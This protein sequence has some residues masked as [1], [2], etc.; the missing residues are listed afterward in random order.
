MFKEG[1]LFAFTLEPFTPENSSI[2]KKFTHVFSQTYRRFLDLQKAEAQ[3][4]EAQIE[5]SLERVRARAMAMQ[6]SSELAELVATLFKELTRL[7]FALTRCYIYIIDPDTLSLQ[8][9]TS[10]TEVDE[11]PTI[12]YLDLP[13]YKALIKAWK[14]RKQKFVYE[15]GGEEKKKV[16]RVLLNET[17][18]SRLPEAVKSGMMSVDRVFLSY[19]FNNFGGLQTG[20]L[21]PLS[22][23][24]L[25]IFSRFGKVFDLTYTRFNDL[26]QAEAQAKEAQIQLALE[27]VRARTMAMQSSEELAEVSYLLNKQVVELGIPTRGCAFNIYNE[28]DST[29]WFS[30]LDGTIPTY[31]TPRENIFLKYYEAGQ[32]GEMLLI[33]EFGGERIKEHY[34]YLATLSVAGSFIEKIEENVQVVP[35]FQIDHVAYFKYGYLLF[36]TLVPAPEAHD[37]FKRFAKEFEQTYTRFLDLKK[38]EAQAREAQIEAALERVRSRTMGMRH[39]DELQEAAVLLF[40]Q[41]VALGVP[42]FATGFNIWD[43]DRKTVTAWMGGQDRMQPPF[44]TSGSEDIF[45]RIYE[46]AQRGDSLFVEEQGGEALKMHYEYMKSIPVFKEIAD[47]MAA[48]GQSFPTFQIMHSAFF[49]HGYLMFITLEPASNAHDI[50]KRFAKVFEQTYT[51]FLDLQKAEE[52]TRE[53]VKQSSLDR[54]RGQIASMRTTKDLERI[55]PIIWHEL[56]SL[57]VPFICPGLFNNSG[58]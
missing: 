41:V 54:V 48:A 52:Q 19:S 26:K 29:E 40:Q 18:Y 17:E 34:K 8:A 33:E 28:H 57:N 11:I 25:D 35:E 22:D 16:D 32:R 30:S 13:Y 56:N 27:R 21:E 24:N 7:D 12:Q 1:G 20:G 58:G 37:V 9:W 47:K 6:N 45:Q 55:T 23:E 15:L 49:S 42:A 10:N 46:A 39:S 5:L 43:D 31:K 38:A 53:A 2:F 44:K 4:R 50:F 3:A 51:R 14:E 36:I